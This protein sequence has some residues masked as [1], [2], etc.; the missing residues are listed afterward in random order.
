VDDHSIVI[1]QSFE[2]RLNVRGIVCDI[3]IDTGVSAQER[4]GQFS[5]Q[6]FF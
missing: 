1:P 6:F 3:V 4:T 2:P 5:G